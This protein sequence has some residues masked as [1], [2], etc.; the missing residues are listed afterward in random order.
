MAGG[1]LECRYG[2]MLYSLLMEARSVGLAVII[3]PAR[4]C[5]K[6]TSKEQAWVAIVQ[7][8]RI[9]VRAGRQ[10]GDAIAGEGEVEQHG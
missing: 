2:E 7:S 9:Q 4:I 5:P 1:E 6:G 10:R 8:V 3:N